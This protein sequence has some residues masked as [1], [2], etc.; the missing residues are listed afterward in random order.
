MLEHLVNDPGQLVGGG[1]DRLLDAQAGPHSTEEGAQGTLAAADGLGRDPQDL[2]GPVVIFE[3]AATHDLAAGYVVMRGQPKPGAEVLVGGPFAHVRADLG[4]QLLDAAD[5]QPVDL[6]QI[7]PGQ[8][9]ELTADVKV[10]RVL[11]VGIDLGVWP[12]GRLGIVGIEARFEGAVLPLDLVVALG[13][14]VAVDV[15]QCQG[16]LER[17]DVLIPVVAGQGFGNVGFSALAATMAQLRQL[18][19]TALAGHNRADDRQPSRPADVAQDLGVLELQLLQ[20]LLHVLNVS[21]AVL[22]EHSPLAQVGPQHDDLGFRAEG[23]APQPIA[24]QALDPVAILDVALAAGHVLDVAGVY[25]A[26][27]QTP[28]LPQIHKGEPRHPRG[29]PSHRRAP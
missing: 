3:R 27:P 18:G 22:D 2:P 14:L 10:G 26:D 13:Q 29:I 25:Q 11:A 21:G 6:R 8:P 16:L 28:P 9:K 17:E 7:D 23:R 1:D 12:Q 19:R 4:Q 15:V 20:V 24:V 5:V